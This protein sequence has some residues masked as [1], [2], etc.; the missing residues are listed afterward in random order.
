MK[1]MG[2]PDYVY[3]PWSESRRAAARARMLARSNTPEGHRK[4][5]GINVPEKLAPIVARE[6]HALRNRHKRDLRVCRA[7]VL[8]FVD[9]LQRNHGEQK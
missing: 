5:Y 2:H 6:A 3:R 1:S 8:W 9:Y 7:F 4:V